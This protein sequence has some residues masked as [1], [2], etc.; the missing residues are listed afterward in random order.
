MHVMQPHGSVLHNGNQQLDGEV[1][2]FFFFFFFF[3]SNWANVITTDSLSRH[4]LIG[5]LKH[6]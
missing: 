1:F 6:S 4:V 2:F 5:F 3:L